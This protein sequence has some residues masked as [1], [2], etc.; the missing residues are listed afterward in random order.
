MST[1]LNLV[2]YL[3]QDFRLVHLAELLEFCEAMKIKT[4]VIGYVLA[5]AIFLF[6]QHRSTPEQNTRFVVVD[7]THSF[8]AARP[9]Y[10]SARHGQYRK[11]IMAAKDRDGYFARQIVLPERY[12]T[13][14]DAPAHFVPGLW[15]VDQIPAERLVAPL[16]ILNVQSKAAR[17]P[18][19]R[20]SLDDIGD[21][22]QV[23]GHIPQGAVIMANT[24][25]DSRWNSV[26]DYRNSDAHQT[27]HFP[28]YS[29]DS[30]RFLVEGRT[31]IGLGID[32]LS[33]DF[34]PSEDFPVHK[35]AL[36][37]SLYQ[38]ENVANLAQAPEFGAT[39]VVA[40][41]KLEGGSEAPARILALT[42]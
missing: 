10:E 38:L 37:H 17:N 3:H 6:A 20:V 19:Y 29:I 7:L 8:D 22:E 11:P 9:T 27:M 13:H 15:T 33:I 30:A 28:G 14:L 2:T 16:V 31:A 32:T 24:G 41:S 25:W 40:P 5:L 34:G 12:G 1:H 36:S 4:F 18:D 39:V 23:H 21:W 26:K 42:K 35:Y